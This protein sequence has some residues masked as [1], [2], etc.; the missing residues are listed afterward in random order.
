MVPYWNITVLSFNKLNCLSKAQYS[1]SFSK[2]SI[3]VHLYI[4]LHVC[5]NVLHFLL[6]LLTSTDV[7]NWICENRPFWHNNWNPM[8]GLK[9]HS[10]TVQAHHIW[11][12]KHSMGCYVVHS[13][14]IIFS[15]EIPFLTMVLCGYLLMCLVL[16]LYMIANR[17]YNICRAWLL[18][19][20]VYHQP[21]H[22]NL[23][24]QPPCL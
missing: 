18:L 8:Y 24:D 12:F 13:N 2:A 6:T 3:D 7:C 9:L 5:Y 11:S 22:E 10:S 14:H 4:W 1:S 21:V 15:F 17:Q 20:I 16:Y 19:F 23:W